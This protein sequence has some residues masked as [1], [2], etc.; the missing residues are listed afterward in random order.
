MMLEYVVG[1]KKKKYFLKKTDPDSSDFSFLKQA[2]HTQKILMTG[3]KKRIAGQ[4][5]KQTNH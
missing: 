1:K 4:Y 2:P 5:L 3:E